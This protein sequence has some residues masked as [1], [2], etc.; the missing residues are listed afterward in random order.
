MQQAVEEDATDFVG[1]GR[2]AC[3]DADV[4][5]KIL[6]PKVSDEDAKF[7]LN[8]LPHPWWVRKLGVHVLGVGMETVSTHCKLWDMNSTN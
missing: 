4:A 7:V 2:P 3:V 6:D 5:A 8:A 1:I